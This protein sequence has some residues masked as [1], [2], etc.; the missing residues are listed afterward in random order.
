MVLVF[1]DR[2]RLFSP[3]VTVYEIWVASR[4]PWK[5]MEFNSYAPTRGDALDNL[6]LVKSLDETYS[7]QNCQFKA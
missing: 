5:A 3:L 2:F 4:Y 6:V 1:T 7:T